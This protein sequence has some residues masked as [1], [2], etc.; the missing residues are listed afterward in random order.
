MFWIFLNTY[1]RTD[2]RF[3]KFKKETLFIDFYLLIIISQIFLG[4]LV[5]GLDAGRI[6]QTWPLMNQSFFPDD[7]QFNF[8]AIFDFDDHSAVQFL[9]RS[10]AYFIL[11]YTLFIAYKISSHYRKYLQDF[12]IVVFLI[13]I[14]VLLGIFTLTSGL[15]TYL[16]SAHQI[17][18][19]LLF[20]SVIYLRFKIT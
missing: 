19:L 12:Y 8:F 11:L 14:Q 13:S 16:A 10:S 4:A 15:N 5:S 3:I 1:N 17:T 6:Y 7:L 18:G 20:F 9:H 2:K